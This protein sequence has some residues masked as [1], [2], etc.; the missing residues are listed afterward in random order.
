[1]NTTKNIA[2]NGIGIAMFVVLSLCLQVLV[3]ENYYLCLGYVVMA[4]YCYS[5]GIVSGTIVGTLGTILYCIL[6][7][8]FRGMPG[9]AL[10]N[11]VIGLII[12]YA[13]K[14]GKEMKNTL[15]EMIISV[16]GI[17]IATVLGIGFV[18]S[19]VECILYAQP[20]LVRMTSNGA[21]CIADVI[22]LIVSLPVCK[23]L[24]SQIAKLSK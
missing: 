2:M 19:G 12:G 24:D 20:F 23:L 11:I 17:C 22:M 18:K 7:N 8:G 10:G 21:A 13:F 15:L 14:I 6:I 4:V 5:V 1:M 9:W 3:F 16:I